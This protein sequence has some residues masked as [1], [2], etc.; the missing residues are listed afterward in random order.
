MPRQFR[1]KYQL[2]KSVLGQIGICTAGNRTK[3]VDEVTDSA[4]TALNLFVPYLRLHISMSE[5][6]YRTANNGI[7]R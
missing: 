6:E 2:T 7:E 5:I 4:N 3:G 1:K